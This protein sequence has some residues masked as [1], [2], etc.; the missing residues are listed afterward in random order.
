M[1]FEGATAKVLDTSG[2]HSQS[3]SD[4]NSTLFHIFVT[5]S[6]IRT[7]VRGSNLRRQ[8]HLLA[9]DIVRIHGLLTRGMEHNG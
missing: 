5:A 3:L 9:G 6:S 2:G 4:F 8:Q 1:M 7:S